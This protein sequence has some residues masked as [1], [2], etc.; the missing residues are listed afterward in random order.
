[1]LN[2]A[3]EEKL[4]KRECID[5][6]GRPRSEEGYFILNGFVEGLDY[7]D[8]ATERWIWSIGRRLSDDAIHASYRADLYD[9]PKYECL[10][11]R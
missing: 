2:V 8:A 1:M 3:M 5:V 10:F 4:Q 9:N 11:L 7:C 6:S